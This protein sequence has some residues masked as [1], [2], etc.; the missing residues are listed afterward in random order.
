MSLYISLGAL[1]GLLL[2]G[3]LW[4]ILFRKKRRAKPTK[5]L[6]EHLTYI[7]VCSSNQGKTTSLLTLPTCAAEILVS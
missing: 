4:N 6:G 3:T 5:V 2:I 7:V 1:V